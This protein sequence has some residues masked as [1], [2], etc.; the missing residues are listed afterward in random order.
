[1]R[2]T[3]NDELVAQAAAG[4]M[5]PLLDELRS[6]RIRMS[7][8]RATGENDRGDPPANDLWYTVLNSYSERELSEK[9]FEQALEAVR[10]GASRGAIPRDVGTNG[11]PA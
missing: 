6:G 5:A 8:T 1:M 9:Q 3:P 2:M 4:D 11:D 10:A 7:G